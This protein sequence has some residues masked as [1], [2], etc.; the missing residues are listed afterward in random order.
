MLK[1]QPQNDIL[2]IRTFERC[3]SHEGGTF[4]NRI[5]S[6]QRRFQRDLQPLPLCENVLRRLWLQ[7]KNPF[8]KTGS[9]RY[10][11]LGI[12]DSRTV[13]NRFHLLISYPACGILLQE[14]EQKA[15][16]VAKWLQSCPTLSDPIDGS[17]PG[18]SIPGILQTRILQWV[19]IFFSNA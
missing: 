3:L 4:T 13:G 9:F 11:Y 7:T 14:P 10:F 16:A 8:N 5:I 6:L 1:S 12:P 15:A 19:A 18:S 17:L 2:G